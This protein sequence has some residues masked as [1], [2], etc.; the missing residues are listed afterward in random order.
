MRSVIYRVYGDL[1][2]NGE[3]GRMWYLQ[4]KDLKYAID[5]LNRLTVQKVQNLEILS[6]RIGSDDAWQ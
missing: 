2:L 6:K 4:T 5:K 1:T 3:T